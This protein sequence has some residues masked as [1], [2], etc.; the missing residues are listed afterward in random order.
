MIKIAPS[1]LACDLSK[2]GEECR[3]VMEAGADWLHFDVM[4]GV[5]VPNISLGI[6]EL[7]AA[8]GAVEAFYD[9]HLML[10]DPLPY[11]E[12]FAEA[13]AD[14][15]TFHIESVSNPERTIREIRRCGRMAGIT[16]CPNTDAAEIFPFLGLVDMV[17]VMSVHPGFGGQRFMASQCRKL[18]Q[19][20]QRAAETGAGRLL[21]EIDGGITA[22]TAATAARAGADILVAGSAIFGAKDRKAALE[23][24]RKAAENQAGGS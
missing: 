12:R 9:V 10:I 6:G 22:R 2:I 14:M 16:L 18:A 3:E 4:D 15:I 21:F 19:I 8:A 13:G 7:R 17:L 11:I 20:K 24:L 1:L 5:L 23:A